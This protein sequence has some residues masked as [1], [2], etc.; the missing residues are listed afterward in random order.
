MPRRSF[1]RALVAL[2]A[3][4]AFGAL[5]APAR[6]ADSAKIGVVKSTLSAPL[7]VAVAKGF[8]KDEGIDADIAFFEAAQPIFVAVVSGDLDFG[9][10]GVTGGMYQL[11]IQNQLRIIGAHS[12]EVPGFNGYGVFVSTPAWNAGLKSLKDIPGHSAGINTVGSSF[13]YSLALIAEKYGF[14]M[15]T[16]TLKPLQQNTAITSALAGAAVDVAVVSN[17]YG[18]G[19]VKEGQAKVLA[20]VGDETPWELGVTVVSTKTADTRGDYIQ[21]FMRAYRRGARYY[22]D[23]VTGPDEREHLNAN[24]PEVIAII[25]KAIGQSED[26]VK[27]AIAYADPDERIGVKDI[28]HQVNWYKDQGMI[29][30]DFNA[31]QVIDRRYVM[32][33]PDK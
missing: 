30:G 28:V 7:Y 18:L 9:V 3:A 27:L 25:A 5:S 15:K 11:A 4:A 29:K 26:Q 8:F 21:R 16:V 2:M 10:S 12:G 13:H 22:H 19:P 32:L 14:D 33:F 31:D 20:W 6:A 23:A 17:V 1:H 24:A